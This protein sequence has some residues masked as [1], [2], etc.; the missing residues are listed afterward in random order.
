MV[1]KT[2]SHYKILEKLGEGGMGVVHRV[3]LRVTFLQTARNACVRIVGIMLLLSLPVHL[4]AQKHNVKF[5]HLTVED[6]LSSNTVLSILQDS[7]GFMW[8]GTS[9]GLNRYDGYAFKEYRHDPTDSTSI[10]DNFIWFDCLYEDSF[11]MI[12]VGT[13]TAGLNRFDPITET[14]KR[15]QH[16]PNE[17]SS[18]STNHGI[19][20]G[21]DRS[22]VLWVGTDEGLN[23]F[24]R[25]TE[26]FE[27]FLHDPDDATSLAHNRIWDIRKTGRRDKTELWIATHN[28]LDRF[29]RTTGRFEHIKLDGLYPKSVKIGPITDIYDDQ[30]GTLWLGSLFG[31]VRLDLQTM[32]TKFY[33]HDPESRN[34]LNFNVVTD[35]WQDPGTQGRVLWLTTRR[36]LNRFDTETETFS[37]YAY[38]PAKPDGLNATGVASLHA[39]MFQRLWIGSHSDGINKLN[40]QI[41]NFNL[42]KH[43]PDDPNGLKGWEVRAIHDDRIGDLWIGTEAGLNKLDRASG[44][45]TKYTFGPD[46][47]SIVGPN[48]V[49]GIAEDE[50]GILW[51]GTW[52]GGLIRFDPQTGQ[53]H[54]YRHEPTNPNSLASNRVGRVFF[55]SFGTLWL[56][57]AGQVLS[58]LLSEDQHPGRFTHFKPAPE[59]KISLE[60]HM[61]FAFLEDSYGGFWVGS[62][63]N[64]LS[65]FNRETGQ[66]TAY[67]HDQ[68]DPTSLSSN[69]VNGMFEIRSER[70]TIMWVGTGNG[71]NRFDR[72]SQTFKRIYNNQPGGSDYVFSMVGDTHNNLWIQNQK[73]LSKFDTHRE[74]FINFAGSRGLPADMSNCYGYHRNGKGEI[75]FGGMGGLIYFHPDS[76][77][78]NQHVPPVLLTD[79]KVLNEPVVL[80]SSITVKKRI[81]LTYDQN[82]FSFEFAALDYTD[83]KKKIST[84]TSWKDWM[85]SGLKAA[86]AASPIIQLSG[87]A[88]TF[89]V[90]RGRTTTAFG[91]KKAFR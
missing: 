85:Q 78:S 49:T 12:W 70:D 35:I 58:R 45:A 18:L 16:D 6:G 67:K 44:V 2:I 8:F 69:V 41:Q 48:V 4:L 73:G 89:F 20:L 3:M 33:R 11:G 27:R 23:R 7:R 66:F 80:D 39:D 64:G 13:R 65:R 60:N 37:H 57:T 72:N 34:S 68:N 47:L 5:E 17:G 77:L 91:M 26:T 62:H 15:F 25:A 14:F 59:N 30:R 71:L 29:D 56:G 75:F 52:G 61:A 46:T 86:V 21:E 90:L 9:E 54:Q 50:N 84:P 40:R 76:I 31:F 88:V 87:Q 53:F 74:T 1:G 82:F 38:D 63:L 55:D 79:F 36:G 43:D 81:D 10:S 42:T 28:G 22:G 32:T 83:S 24:D 51:L 19:G